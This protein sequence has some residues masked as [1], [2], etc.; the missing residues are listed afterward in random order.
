MRIIT[1]TCCASESCPAE[2]IKPHLSES[3]H[4]SSSRAVQGRSS[5]HVSGTSLFQHHTEF[6]SKACTLRVRTWAFGALIFVA[7]GPS[8]FPV[9]SAAGS[10]IA[11][12][13]IVG[14]LPHHSPLRA[15]SRSDVLPSWDS[16]LPAAPTYQKKR[17]VGRSTTPFFETFTTSPQNTILRLPIQNKDIDVH[18]N[19]GSMTVSEREDVGRTPTTSKTNCNRTA[20][21]P[22]LRNWYSLSQQ[23]LLTT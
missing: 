2:S 10:V 23:W 3:T 13:S 11:K 5:D 7:A 4:T 12:C 19:V 20:H 8:R 17:S 16:Q 15:H 1:R 22:T 6:T 21:K 18:V 9:T 14:T